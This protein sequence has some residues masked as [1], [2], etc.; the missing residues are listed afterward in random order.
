[1]P[2]DDG[3]IELNFDPE[4]LTIG[5]MEQL[6]DATGMQLDV[7]TKQ[8]QEGKFSAKVLKAVVWMLMSADDPSFTIEDAAKVKIGVLAVAAGSVTDVPPDQAAAGDAAAPAAR[9]RR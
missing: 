6:E 7:L 5:Q 2:V 1:M 3:P 4:Q 9:K 8:M